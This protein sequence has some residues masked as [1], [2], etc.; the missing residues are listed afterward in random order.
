MGGQQMEGP[1]MAKIKKDKMG[2]EATRSYANSSAD[3]IETSLADILGVKPEEL[4]SILDPKNSG[5][6]KARVAP[7]VGVIDSKIKT[8]LGG[9][10]DVESAIENLKNKAQMFGLTN[11]RKSGVAPGSI[12]EKEWPKFESTLGNIDLSLS[13]E[14]FIK[15][16]RDIYMQ[17][18]RGRD[19]G[20]LDYTQLSGEAPADAPEMP[21]NLG[22][23]D[24]EALQWLAQN[25]NDPR[26]EA[27]RQQLRGK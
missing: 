4:G 24:L 19:A 25:P 27:V 3:M 5:K 9:T 16:M 18:R 2:A 21:T 20:E 14:A 22:P 13:E 23:E 15:Q 8:L 26:A 12:T 6:A 11:L 10:R 1:G 7:A 17:A